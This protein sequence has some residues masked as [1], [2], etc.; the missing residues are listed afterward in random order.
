MQ[1]IASRTLIFDAI[2]PGRVNVVAHENTASA[3]GVETQVV[4]LRGGSVGGK[5]RY[6]HWYVKRDGRWR[7]YLSF[8]A[9]E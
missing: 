5:R 9:R 2:T 6:V 3:N 4:S 8:L 7:L 1:M